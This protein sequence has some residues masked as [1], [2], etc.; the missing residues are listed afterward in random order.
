MKKRFKAMMWWNN[1]SPNTRQKLTNEFRE[2]VGTPRKWESLTGR[3]IEKIYDE[4]IGCEEDDSENNGTQKSP[5]Q[6]W[7]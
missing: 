3:E 2:L 7:S 4:E 6:P 1:L 5:F